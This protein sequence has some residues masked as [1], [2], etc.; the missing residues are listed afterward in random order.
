MV[1]DWIYY[2]NIAKDYIISVKSTK[3]R[4]YENE[5]MRAT[6]NQKKTWKIL[7]ELVNG[8]KDETKSEINFDGCIASDNNVIADKFN[9]YY[10]ESINEIINTIPNQE[11]LPF[12]IYKDIATTFAFE[13]V[14]DDVVLRSILK[15]KSKGD[16]EFINK[17]I[18]L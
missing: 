13:C 5:L 1:S 9:N 11:E 6:G 4:Y 15:I 3:S 18:L 8:V 16:I 2:E 14:T 10:I 7:K 12:V 17:S